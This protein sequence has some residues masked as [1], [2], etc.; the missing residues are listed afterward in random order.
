ME[1]GTAER[2][3]YTV[4]RRWEVIKPLIVRGETSRYIRVQ[5]T[6]TAAVMRLIE[7]AKRRSKF[8]Q[9]TLAI[10][11]SEISEFIFDPYLYQ[12]KRRKEKRKQ[13]VKK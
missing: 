7:C 5:T 12:E 6:E 9:V 10:R 1:S 13:Y 2:D 3:V 4:T 8:Y 11:N